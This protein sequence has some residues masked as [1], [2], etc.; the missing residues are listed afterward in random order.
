[1]LEHRLHQLAFAG[2]LLLVTAAALPAQKLHVHDRW[3]E[4]AIVIDP[5][6]TQG[7][8]HQFVSEVGVVMYFRPLTSARP[9]GRGRIEF[10]I[11]SSATRIDDADAAWNDTFTHPDSTH[12]LFEGDALQIPGLTLRMGVTDRIDAGVYFTKNV[13][14][15]Y[16]FIGGQV[17]YSMPDLNGSFDAAGRLS[18]VRAI[19][20][21]DLSASVYGVDLLVSKNVSV[22]SPY[23]GVSGYLSHGHERTAKVDLKDENVLGVQGTIGVAAR[24]SIIR[25]GAEYNLARVSGYSLKVAFG[26]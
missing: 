9:L 5:S 6:L 4:C 24:I 22:L 2:A 7:A 19:G 16:G 21:E 25:L 23:V 20:P 3:D 12:W 14:S 26:S 1:M 11:L 13:R 17:Q 18:M 8:W 10:A 15:N